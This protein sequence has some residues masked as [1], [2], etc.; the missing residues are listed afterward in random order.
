MNGDN[1]VGTVR[2]RFL[3]RS[4]QGRRRRARCGH[5]RPRP[6]GGGD[7]RCS[8]LAAIIEDLAPIT[9]DSGTTMMPNR[10][11]TSRG[12]A[13]RVRD[14]RDPAAH[15]RSVVPGRCRTYLRTR[16]A[17]RG[18]L[19]QSR[20][21]TGFGSRCC[22]TERW[23]TVSASKTYAR[24]AATAGSRGDH[25]VHAGIGE[26]CICGATVVRTGSRRTYFCF[27][28]T[29]HATVATVRRA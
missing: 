14:H 4:K 26:N 28:P 6:E 12:S 16:H 27:Q 23:E 29:R 22:A 20:P 9:T 5:R 24:T 13:S 11:R 21:S 8:R 19:P 7:V 3:V 17:A 10:S 2:L 15:G 18:Q 1:G 25:L